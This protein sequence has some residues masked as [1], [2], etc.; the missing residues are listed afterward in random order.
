MTEKRPKTLL[1]IEDDPEIERLIKEMLFPYEK[2][3]KVIS[4]DN[5]SE[6]L[7]ELKAVDHPDAVLCDIMMLYGKEAGDLLNPRGD[8]DRYMETG[9]RLIRHYRDYEKANNLPSIWIGFI[10][11]RSGLGVGKEID[12][13][14]S[15][16]HGHQGKVYFKP[17]DSFQL[18]EDLMAVLGL[19]YKYAEKGV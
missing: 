7:S 13:L 9:L 4:K 16:K 3:L 5:A 11:A 15:V 19:E 10:T 14:I 8:D 17:F 18:E 12:Q 1:L 2:H 6:A